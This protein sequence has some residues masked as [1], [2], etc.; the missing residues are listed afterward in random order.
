MIKDIKVGMEFEAELAP[1]SKTLRYDYSIDSSG[2]RLIVDYGPSGNIIN[3]VV[4]RIQS[5][6]CILHFGKNEMFGVPLE[7][8]SDY[9]ENQWTLPGFP[10]PAHGNKRTESSCSCGAWSTYGHGIGKGGG[11]SSWCDIERT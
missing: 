3:A 5:N 2:T 10:I 9:R 4:S 7:G 6:V 11:H 1:N 8:H